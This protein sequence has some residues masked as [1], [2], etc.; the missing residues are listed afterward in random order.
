MS[1]FKPAFIGITD[2]IFVFEPVCVKCG[3]EYTKR[4]G[5]YVVCE[6]CCVREHYT[7]CCFGGGYI[8]EDSVIGEENL[9]NMHRLFPERLKAGIK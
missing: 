2:G 9:K 5:E 8:E 1:S 7:D 3:P 6:K 4:S